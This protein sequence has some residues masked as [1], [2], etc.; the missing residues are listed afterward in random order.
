MVADNIK[1]ISN[2][3]ENN[4]EAATKLKG[5]T[6]V[7][8]VV[9]VLNG[10]GVSVSEEDFNEIVSALT[11]EEIPVELLDLVAGGGF[12]DFFWGFCD[13]LREGWDDTKNFFT[14]LFS[15]K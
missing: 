12:R 8:E 11:S 7:D 14:G 13:G 15:K 3:L 6:S 5:A 4:E 10:Y 2:L 1:A 9:S